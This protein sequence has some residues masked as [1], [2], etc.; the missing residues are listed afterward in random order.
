MFRARGAGKGG[1]GGRRGVAAAPPA[2]P[3]AVAKCPSPQ[4]RGVASEVR[5]VDRIPPTRAGGTRLRA[6]VGRAAWLRR[7]RSEDIADALPGNRR[8]GDV[9]PL[10]PEEVHHD[11]LSKTLS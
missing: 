1:S 9:A 5:P 8:S 7:T 4:G 2:V 3:E 6:G 11:V 10:T